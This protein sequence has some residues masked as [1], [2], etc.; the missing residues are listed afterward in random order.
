MLWS[1][2]FPL[3]IPKYP[4]LEGIY[5]DHED[6]WVQP[7]TPHMITYKLNIPSRRVVQMFLEH[8]QAW[9]H[10]C[11]PREPVPVLDHPPSIFQ[12]SNP[13]FP[14]SSF[15]SFHCVRSPVTRERR[16][17][18]PSLLLTPLEEVVDSNEVTRQ[19][20]LSWINLVPWSTLCNSCTLVHLSSSLPS[21]ST[22]HHMC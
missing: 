4:E 6:H 8:K 3:R 9:C 11:F 1:R 16:P 10:E 15:R 18:S 13:N 14:R 2:K 21:F 5:E 7:M 17:T 20:P 19:S 22:A 12:I